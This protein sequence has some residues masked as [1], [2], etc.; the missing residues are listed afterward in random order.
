VT[1][2]VEETRGEGCPKGASSIQLM[3]GSHDS[4]KALLP[5][6]YLRVV[7]KGVDEPPVAPGFAKRESGMA[8][9]CFPVMRLT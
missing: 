2:W 7:L 1:R 4:G 9:P 6:S 5:H 8:V 3:G